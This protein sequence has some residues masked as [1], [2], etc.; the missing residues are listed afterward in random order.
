MDKEKEPIVIDTWSKNVNHIVSYWLYDDEQSYFYW[1]GQ[2][3]R[4]KHEDPNRPVNDED[5][6]IDKEIARSGL[7]E[8]LKRETTEAS[9]LKEG[10]RYGE[11]LNEVF[12]QVDWDQIAGSFLGS[13][14]MHELY[15]DEIVY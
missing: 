3:K 4:H 12:S 14:E 6:W 11:L 8:Q 9:R 10:D 15:R 2:A 1:V 7:A 5:D 13:L